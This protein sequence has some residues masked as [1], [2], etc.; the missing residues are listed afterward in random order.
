MRR[1]MSHNATTLSSEERGE[2]VNSKTLRVSLSAEEWQI[3]RARAAE[4]GR[5]V[6]NYATRLL[7]AALSKPQPTSGPRRSRK[8]D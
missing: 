2:V 6:A 1:R 3:L 7:R 5:S 8:A 4:E